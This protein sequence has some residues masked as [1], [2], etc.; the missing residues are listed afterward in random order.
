MY[1]LPDEAWAYELTGPPNADGGPSSLAVH[2]A[3]TTPGDGPFTPKSAAHALVLM[4]DGR[5]PWPILMRFMRLVEQSG[6]IVADAQYG[7]VSGDLTLSRN[8]WRFN[9]RA[10]EVNSYHFGEHDCWC[11]ELYDV[12]PGATRNNYVDVRIPD[13]QPAGGPFVAAP[14]EV[15]FTV[16]GSLTLPWP[17]LLRLVDAV[18]ASGDIVNVPAVVAPPTDT[19]GG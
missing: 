1:L 15:T 7:L 18:M 5:F 11:Y 19:A 3:D 13:L 9:E 17:V 12:D 4:A 16:H 2:I 8:S 14:A 10:L 6:D